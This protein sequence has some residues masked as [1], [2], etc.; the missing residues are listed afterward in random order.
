MRIQLDYG[1]RARFMAYLVNG[2]SRYNVFSIYPNSDIRQN[3]LSNLLHLKISGSITLRNTKTKTLS[4]YD[5]SAFFRK[6]L[7]IEI[8][9]NPGIIDTM[10]DNLEP[11]ISKMVEDIPV[12][13]INNWKDQSICELFFK[14]AHLNIDV[15]WENEG[16]YFRVKRNPDKSVSIRVLRG[17]NADYDKSRIP[18]DFLEYGDVHMATSQDITIIEA[19]ALSS[20]GMNMRGIQYLAPDILEEVGKAMELSPRAIKCLSK[21]QR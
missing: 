20:T 1:D 17:A 18:K 2:I 4:F 6:A 11:A 5:K 15:D 21:I 3:I 19:P 14:D 12:S 8:S 9:D 7:E 13:G 10:V 16:I